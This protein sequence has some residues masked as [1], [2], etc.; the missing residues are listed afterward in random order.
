[1]F[2]KI[3]P[4][5]LCTIIPVVAFLLWSLSNNNNYDYS[6]TIANPV[7]EIEVDSVTIV[8]SIKL[9]E[10][11]EFEKVED[12]IVT[13]LVNIEPNHNHVKC[14]A[15]NI[16]HESAG[17]P[18][19]GQVAVG[20]V[21][22]NRVLHGFASDPCKVIYQSHKIMVE[23]KEKIRCQFSW[24]CQGKSQP[25]NSNPGYIEA[26]NIAKR[27]LT[28]NAWK[29]DIPDNI[30]FFHN[31]TVNPRWKYR[32]EFSIGGHVFYSWNKPK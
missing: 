1:M 30:L 9:P 11:E 23:D 15:T 28:E 31:N 16:Y 20:R 27:I 25:S 6:D 5:I 4:I 19:M 10:I 24:V 12:T 13:K 18:F 22:M 32:K 26:E 2:S 14:M 8:S 7:L 3:K 29:D 17:E 21:V